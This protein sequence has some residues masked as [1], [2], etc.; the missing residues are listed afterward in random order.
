MPTVN[1]GQNEMVLSYL[2]KIIGTLW[3]FEVGLKST[4]SFVL[5]EDEAILKKCAK[6]AHEGQFS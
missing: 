3:P 2:Q 6:M 1:L 5:S 4:M